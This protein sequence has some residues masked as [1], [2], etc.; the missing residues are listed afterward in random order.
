MVLNL[1]LLVH[2]S[3]FFQGDSVVPAEEKPGVLSSLEMDKGTDRV[4]TREKRGEEGE[5]LR[6]E[7]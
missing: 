6:D 5:D 4:T 1:Y 3:T 2:N 7:V